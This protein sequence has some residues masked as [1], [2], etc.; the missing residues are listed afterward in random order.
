MTLHELI[1]SSYQMLLEHTAKARITLLHP[2]S[3]YRSVLVA[4]LIRDPD[5]NTFYYAMGPDDVNISSFLAGFAHDL[6]DQESL[7]GRNL[8]RIRYDEVNDTDLLLDTLAEDLE[9]LSETPY[10]LILDEYDRADS[11]DDLQAFIEQLIPRLPE[12]CRVV[13]NSRTL[14]RLPWVSLVAQKQA[15]V[16]EDNRLVSSDFYGVEGEGKPHLDVRALGPGRVSL[17][18]A[19]VSTWEGHLPRLLFFFALDRPIV[20]RAE[21]CQAFWPELETDQ[22][23]NVFHVTKRRLHKAL[24]FDVLVHEGGYYRVNPNVSIH[25]DIMDFVGSLVKGRAKVKDPVTQAWQHAIDIYRGP[26]LQGHDDAWIEERRE[27]FCAGYLE[28]LTEMALARKAE[29][30]PEH[31][32]G[33]FLRAI[34]E[35]PRREDLHREVMQIYADLGRRSEAAAHYQQLE[36]ELKKDYNAEPEPETQALY[37]E[38]MAG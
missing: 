30:R 21:I 27:D 33:L 2:R 14:P 18:N 36:Q 20:T 15:T 29:D 31:A 17:D 11:A 5:V 24:G 1:E 32:L 7:F 35:D 13:I 37:D 25:Y 12:K 34:T 22:A 28:A 6:A 4:Q 16:L 3:R 19:E 8:N 9:E 10:V 26:F 23:V 38:I